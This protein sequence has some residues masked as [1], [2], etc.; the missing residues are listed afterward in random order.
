MT[1]TVTVPQTSTPQTSTP[2]AQ[3]LQR[4][5]SQYTGAALGALQQWRAW[6]LKF[7]TE[8]HEEYGPDAVA[9]ATYAKLG[10]FGPVRQALENVSL[11]QLSAAAELGKHEAELVAFVARK[12]VSEM[13]NDPQATPDDA[14]LDELV[15]L[16]GELEH[17]AHTHGHGIVSDLVYEIEELIY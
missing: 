16:L 8:L 9:L 15:L 13:E 4:R 11:R 1:Q 6:I 14:E 3:Q 17:R 5:L 10:D 2:H 7:R 12:L